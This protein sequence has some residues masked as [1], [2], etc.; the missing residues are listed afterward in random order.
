MS[1]TFRGIRFCFIYGRQL[2]PTLAV[3]HGP[4]GRRIWPFAFNWRKLKKYYWQRSFDFSVE[5][6]YE[7]KK[8]IKGKLKL[9]LK[10]GW[11][12][13]D[14]QLCS[15]N[16]NEWYDYEMKE[17]GIRNGDYVEFNHVL[18]PNLFVVLEHKKT[19][20]KFIYSLLYGELDDY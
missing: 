15:A 3:Y 1:R 20:S 8:D 7:T 13:Y 9:K 17:Y 5:Y 16:S 2:C 12:L 6:Y 4:A 18:C 10:A 19:G 14:L 11:K